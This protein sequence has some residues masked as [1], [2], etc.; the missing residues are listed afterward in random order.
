MASIQSFEVFKTDLPFK[1][2]FKHAAAARKFSNSI[3]VKAIADDGTVGF[4]EGLPRPYVSGETQDSCMELLTN[5]FLPRLKEMEFKSYDEVISFL[6][7]CDG[8]PPA[9]WLDGTIPHSSAWCAMELSLLDVFGK[10]FEKPAIPK[11]ELKENKKLRYSAVASADRGWKFT[12]SALKFHLFGM[13]HVKLKVDDEVG[14]SAAK[15][16]LFI[17]GKKG[18]VR[19]DV[20]MGWSL[21]QALEQMPEFA[22]IGVT[23]FEQPIAKEDL[24]GLARLVEETGLDVMADESLNTKASLDT[25]LERKACTAINVRVSKC[26]GLIA[27]RKRCQ[28]GREAGLKLQ[29]GCQVGESSIQ[30]AA[31]LMLIRSEPDIIY[32]EGCYGLHLLEEDPAHPLLQ[33][34]YGGRPPK[35]PKGFGLGVEVN[36]EMIRGYS[37]ATVSV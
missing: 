37:D 36:E 22:K 6:E 10:V 32:A 33:F 13:N 26:G 23:S 30:S 34:G 35:I 19:V 7:D 28:Q 5:N 12:K 31:N 9:E 17:L 24:D 1:I 14:I 11:E 20:N 3:F 21:E 8:S 27:A 4:G 18:D 15:E 16:L 25:L 2:K 29:V